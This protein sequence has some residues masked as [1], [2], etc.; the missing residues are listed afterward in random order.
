METK[1]QYQK[2]VP[3]ITFRAI[4]PAMVPNINP[5]RIFHVD[6]SWPARNDQIWS[7]VH[8][9]GNHGNYEIQK[10]IFLTNFLL[11]VILIPLQFCRNAILRKL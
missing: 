2:S 7:F 6:L 8:F 9:P 4:F 10:N 5:D 1:S 3:L 11:L